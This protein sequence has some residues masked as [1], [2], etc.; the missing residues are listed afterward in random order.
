MMPGWHGEAVL[1]KAGRIAERCSQALRKEH[2][3]RQNISAIPQGLAWAE[4]QGRRVRRPQNWTL[5]LETSWQQETYELESPCLQAWG[6]LQ[7]AASS[8][9]QRNPDKE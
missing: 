6:T 1:E 5:V 4:R 9:R 7:P 3:L 2:R 8:N